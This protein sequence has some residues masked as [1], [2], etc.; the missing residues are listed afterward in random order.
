MK[1]VFLIL[2]VIAA[3][4]ELVS[5]VVSIEIIHVIA[6]PSLMITLGLYYFFSTNKEDRS[7]TVLFAL[8]FS[9]GGD[10]LL[11]NEDYFIGGL[12]S[13][14]LAHVLYIFAYR[15]HRY[16]ETENALQ[17]IQRIRMA[18]P[19]ILAGTGL[20]VVLYP[21][22]GDLRIPVVVYATVLVLMALNA[23]FRFGRTSSLSFWLVFIGAVFF[24]LSDSL[25]AINKFLM[26]L[27]HAS[28][29]VMFTYITAQFMIV[30]GLI[31]HD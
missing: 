8:L 26:P 10:V 13:F 21:V 28:F 14:L 5:A 22:L 2:F 6:K 25:L 4:A 16:E 3:I 18:F 7:R 15:K 17:G 20:V 12:V 30:E 29:S 11:M 23:L 19:I 27:S 9:F 31:R 24:M 1:K